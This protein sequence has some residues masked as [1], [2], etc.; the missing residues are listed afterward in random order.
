MPALK[1]CGLKEVVRELTGDLNASLYLEGG[2]LMA[3]VISRKP[4]VSKEQV[5]TSG[6]TFREDDNLTADQVASITHWRD[7]LLASTRLSY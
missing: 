6:L 1:D 7:C 3:F 4:P 2:A 5:V